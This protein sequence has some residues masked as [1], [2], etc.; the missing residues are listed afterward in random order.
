MGKDLLEIGKK[1]ISDNLIKGEYRESKNILMQSLSS[2]DACPIKSTCTITPLMKPKDRLKG[3]REIRSLYKENLESWGNP[4]LQLRIRL[5]DIKLKIQ[6]Q[7]IIDIEKGITMS[8]RM[9]LLLDLESR[10]ID[11]LLKYCPPDR[12]DNKEIGSVI[13]MSG[14]DETPVKEVEAVENEEKKEEPHGIEQSL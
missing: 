8:K 7:S 1:F 10:Y 3:C 4:I 2:C 5:A 13:E 9:K 6:Q 11:K 12:K 14:Y